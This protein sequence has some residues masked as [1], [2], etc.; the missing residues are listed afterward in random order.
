ML[1]RSGLSVTQ[2]ISYFES[3]FED[4]R[5]RNLAVLA[6]ISVNTEEANLPIGKSWFR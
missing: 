4:E 6:C 5:Q 2:L 3:E 1:E